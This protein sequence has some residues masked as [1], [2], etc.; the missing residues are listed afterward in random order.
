[1]VALDPR[2]HATQQ[3]L[4]ARLALDQKI[5][6]DVDTLDKDID[7]ALAAR[8]NLQKAITAHRVTDSQAGDVLAGLN[9]DISDAAQ[10]NM[11]SSEGSLLYETKLRDHLAY[12]AADVD[13][14]YGRPTASEYSV[15]QVLDQQARAAEQKL[16]ADVAAANRLTA[17]NSGSGKTPA[18]Q[19]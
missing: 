3:D 5:Y 15:F 4:E 11:K 16:T 13:L 8:D 12:I 9:R 2:L 14:A 10:M 1:V 7:Q 19:Q 18:G 17:A 6:A